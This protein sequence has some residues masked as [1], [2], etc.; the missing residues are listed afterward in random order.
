MFAFVS[1]ITML[2]RRRKFNIK[3]GV[4]VTVA[5][6]LML[7]ANPRFGVVAGVAGY[8]LFVGA[9]GLVV[10]GLFKAVKLCWDLGN[11]S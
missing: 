2:T 6:F 3:L 1:G 8:F 9:L 4:I 7:L 5:G 10:L 11:R